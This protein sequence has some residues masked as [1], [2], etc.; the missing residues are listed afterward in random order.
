MRLHAEPWVVIGGPTGTGKSALAVAIAEAIGGEVVNY[1]SVQ[2]YRGFD[3]GS[4]KPGID[5]RA[6]VPHHLFD[7]AEASSEIDAAE[8]ARIASATC[9]EIA[10]RGRRPILVGGTGFYL[11]ALLRGLPE[12]PGRDEGVRKRLR[13]IMESERGR[14]R[15]HR[16][17]A[18]VDPL[19]A[20]RIAAADRHRIERALEV[21]VLSNRPISSWPRPEAGGLGVDACILA[22][23]TERT[24]LAERLDRRVAELYAN[25]LVDETRALLERYPAE[26]RPFGSIGYAEA[27]R[28][29][30]GEIDLEAAIVETRRRTRAYAKRQMTW[31]RA[32]RDVHWI[33]AGRPFERIREESLDT[34]RRFCDPPADSRPGDAITHE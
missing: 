2:I 18:R 34:I 6:R 20:R 13:R 14:E 30:R 32:E 22:L 10:A 11:R 26:A 4:A 24:V 21:W 8:F 3:I 25:G 12:M 16:W 17:L 1:D 31:F 28:V 9:R 15:L 7:L 27:V 33:D 23:R 29:V 19:S 5:L